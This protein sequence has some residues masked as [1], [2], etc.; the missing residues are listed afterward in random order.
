MLPSLVNLII[1]EL[2]LLGDQVDT[3]S[4]ELQTEPM[5]SQSIIASMHHG[6]KGSPVC[7]P[8]L[9]SLQISVPGI[10]FPD[11]E[12]LSMVQ[13]RSSSTSEAIERLT[14]VRLNIREHSLAS[15][16]VDAVQRMRK[17]GMDIFVQ[18]SQGDVD[19]RFQSD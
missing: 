14:C 6:K 13:S 4:S 19:M 5:I 12:L 7:L 10:S 2:S 11:E 18:D 9:K 15:T 1:E 17:T 8:R 16:I 3:L